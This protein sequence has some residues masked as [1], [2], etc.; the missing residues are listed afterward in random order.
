[1]RARHSAR[2]ASDNF[3]KDLIRHYESQNRKDVFAGDVFADLCCGDRNGL[4]I[5]D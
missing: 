1:M 5:R 4:F 3:K 2:R